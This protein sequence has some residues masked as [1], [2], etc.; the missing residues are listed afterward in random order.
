MH[1]DDVF[2]NHS[3]LTFGFHGIYPW[4][5]SGNFPVGRAKMKMT[6]TP[7]IQHMS[8]LELFMNL[9]FMD[10]IKYVFIPETNKHLN[11]SMNLSEY[12]LVVVI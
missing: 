4:H 11:S 10:Y 3:S 2:P 6:P 5:Q 7:R 8:R 9:Y 1:P 12:F